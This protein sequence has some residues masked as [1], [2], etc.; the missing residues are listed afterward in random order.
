MSKPPQK[1]DVPT[2]HREEERRSWYFDPNWSQIDHWISVLRADP[3]RY[4]VDRC[5]LCKRKAVTIA[6]FAPF[7]DTDIAFL[8]DTPQDKTRFV[9]FGL[10]QR[11]AALPTQERNCRVE[12]AIR[13]KYSKCDP[14]RVQ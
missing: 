12:D 8:I 10:C 5:R 13:A 2:G 7:P 4:G 9:F 1:P 6:F 3:R 11:C 14:T